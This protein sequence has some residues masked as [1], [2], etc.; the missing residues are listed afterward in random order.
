VIRPLALLALLALAGCDSRS[1]TPPPADLA[2]RAVYDE[3]DAVALR[4]ARPEELF[5]VKFR[6][7][8]REI[9]MLGHGV[10][11]R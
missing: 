1:L 2:A 5:P 4:A 9:C 10:S 7:E 6:N 11:P 8:R 3:C